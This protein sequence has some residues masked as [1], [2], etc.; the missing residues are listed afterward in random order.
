MG[1]NFKATTLQWVGSSVG[2][3]A[4]TKNSHTKGFADIDFVNFEFDER[5][6]I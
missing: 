2:F 1:N 5:N 3:Y 4:L 6:K